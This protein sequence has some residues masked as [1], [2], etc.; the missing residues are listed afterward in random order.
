MFC[1]KCGKQ[2]PDDSV[3]C[4]ECGV[5]LI[6]APQESYINNKYREYNAEKKP[7]GNNIIVSQ[8]TNVATSKMSGQ[9]VKE[10]FY[11]NGKVNIIGWACTLGALL[12]IMLIIVITSGIGANLFDIHLKED[13][14]KAPAPSMY[15][16]ID[17]EETNADDSDAQK[18]IEVLDPEE[19]DSTKNT[20]EPEVIEEPDESEFI[21]SEHFSNSEE[22]SSYED[23][24]NLDGA[25]EG[26]LPNDIFE[27]IK[28][29]YFSEING[30]RI[31]VSSPSTITWE[32]GGYHTTE[33][34]LG[35]DS[36]GKELLLYITIG[37]N[38]GIILSVYH[39][40][41]GGMS[42][43]TMDGGGWDYDKAHA[44]A[45]LSRISKE[46]VN[47]FIFP[48]SSERL[49]TESDLMGFSN[50]E[51]RKARNE[52]AAR[53]GRR[54]KDAELQA[55]FDEQSWY[56]GTI[57]P[58]DFNKIVKL[59]DIEQKNMEFIQKHER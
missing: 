4:P 49:L 34:I 30:I 54:F 51:L 25:H 16:S 52:I 42:M 39:T 15:S 47:T 19:Q 11:K 26:S 14:R 33:S 45:A 46:V 53:H 21:D 36:L 29:T 22:I 12:S 3:F 17:A 13:K 40:D 56:N 37:G 10:F 2:I 23:S 24:W 27:E 35:C 7:F 48:D 9:Y 5:P 55:Y 18:V 28:G 31:S 20:D 50:D 38:E 41:D 1:D 44:H 43:L 32:D 6:Y 8:G 59:S 57:E 58:D